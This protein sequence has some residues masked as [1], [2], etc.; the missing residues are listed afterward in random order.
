MLHAEEKADHSLAA[1]W[2]VVQLLDCIL[3]ENVLLGF[4]CWRSRGSAATMLW[5]KTLR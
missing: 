3:V 5:I 4:T 1:S 2:S